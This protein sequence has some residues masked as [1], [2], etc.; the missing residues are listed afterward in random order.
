MAAKG[1]S[2]SACP[3]PGGAW[4]G[5][6]Y[7]DAVPNP[8]SA[9]LW[10]MDG[11]IVDTEPFWIRAETALVE[12]FGGRWGHEQALRLVGRGL[13]DS[14]R[15]LQEHGVRM[16]VAEIVDTLTDDVVRDLAGTTPW[17]PGALELLRAVRDAGVPT[18][19]VTMSVRRMAEAIVAAIPFPAFDVVVSGTD[20]SRPKPFPDA[21][22]QAAALLGI[23]VTEAVAIEDSPTGLA[24][25]VAAGAT[26]VGVPHLV[27]LPA[28]HWTRWPTLEGR[29]L[30]DLEALAPRTA[31]ARA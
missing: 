19:L 12:R 20:V 11:T 26:V 8:L 25:A 29:G 18:A 21:Y 28:G 24:S 2:L 27:P 17:R 22:E 16:A 4:R 23:D 30:A 1:C 9:V 31:G 7:P 3:G 14:A 15:I 5:A 6:L 10:D 13:E